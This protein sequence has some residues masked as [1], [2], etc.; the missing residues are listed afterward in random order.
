MKK[1]VEL[2]LAASFEQKKRQKN[3]INQHE[4][5]INHQ[6]VKGKMVELEYTFLQEFHMHNS[7]L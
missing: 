1:G 3:S 5:S 7:T 4:N 2:F 6:M